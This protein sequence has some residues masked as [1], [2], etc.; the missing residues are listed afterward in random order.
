VDKQGQ[1]ERLHGHFL[2]SLW[3]LLVLGKPERYNL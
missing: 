2:C 3:C 1:R